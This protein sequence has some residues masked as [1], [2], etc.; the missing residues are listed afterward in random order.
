M[1]NLAICENSFI[2]DFYG[3]LRFSEYFHEA[4]T[5]VRVSERRGEK[6][7]SLLENE[8]RASS[9]LVRINDNFSQSRLVDDFPNSLIPVLFTQRSSYGRYD[10]KH[11][12]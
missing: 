4:D 5:Y 2:N 1:T 10:C 6:R 3:Q 11:R 9:I 7:G 8:G 12:F